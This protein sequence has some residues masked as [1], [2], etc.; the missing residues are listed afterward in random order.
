M[1]KNLLFILIIVAG[2][3]V[4]CA[5]SKNNNTTLVN[6][7][8][9]VR[10]TPDAGGCPCCGSGYF[11]SRLDTAILY[12]CNSLPALPVITNFPANVKIT[13]HDTTGLIFCTW[14]YIVIDEIRL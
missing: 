9:P 13:F 5:K 14:Q 8:V 4:S 11:V 3:T 12:H 10:I 2:F 1:K 6:T 7:F